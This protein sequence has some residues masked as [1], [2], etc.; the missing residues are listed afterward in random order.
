MTE[1]AAIERTNE[2]RR[3]MSKTNSMLHVPAIMEHPDDITADFA[4]AANA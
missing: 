2:R 3:T 4:Q 1:D